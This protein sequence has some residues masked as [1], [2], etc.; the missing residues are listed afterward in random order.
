MKIY[1]Y[2]AITFLLS[3]NMASAQRVTKAPASELNI[4]PG[5]AASVNVFLGTSGD[6]GQLSP[7]AS[8]P[9]SMLS[10]GPQTYPNTH[11]GYEYEAKRFLGFT[12]N[13][14]EGVGC[15]GSGGNILIKPFTGEEADK[16]LIK[17]KQSGTPGY[18]RVSFTNQIIA[19]L[20]AGQK[21]GMHRYRFPAGNNGYLVELAH[22]LANKFVAEGHVAT[23]KALSGWVEART[24][25][26]VGTYK[27]YY[28][29]EFSKRVQWQEIP[30]HK[31][32]AKFITTTEPV[33]IKVGMSSVNTDY[34]KASIFKGTF[35]ELKKDSHDAWDRSLGRIAVTGDPEQRKLFYSLLYRTQQS[36]YL[37]SEPDGTYRG[38]DGKVQKSSEEFYNG[39]SIWDNYRTQLPLL[40][41][42][43]P[44]RYGGMMTSLAALYRSGKKDYATQTE[45]SNTVRTE[46]TIVVLLDAYRKGYPVKFEPIIDSLASEVDHLDYSKPDK[47]LEASYDSW[48]LS[49][50][51][52][53]IHK[54]ELSDK[55]RQK[56]LDY[57]KYW[58]KDF[59]NINANDVDK[60]EARNLYQGTIWQYRWF[61][62]FDVKGLINLTGGVSTFTAQLDQFFNEDH[63]N[64]A[65][66]PDQQVPAMYNAAGQ[67]WK[68][69]ELMHRFAADT[70]IQYFFNDNSKGID[71]FVDKIYKN[72]PKAYIR[73]MD[74]DAGAMSAWYVLTA[75]GLSS[76]CPGWPVYYLNV[77]L[78]K[79]VKINWTGKKAFEIEVLNYGANN[80][81]IKEVTL[82]G[83]TIKRNYITQQ[84]IIAG[85][86]LVI[87][88]SAKPEINALPENWVSSIEP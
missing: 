39:W 86:K 12:H 5:P 20:T 11:T 51:Y 40:S 38:T 47:T 8:Y 15:R 78:M 6:H 13:R 85:G 42:G 65:N 24:T 45:P 57:K 77:P 1:Q 71:P 27:I 16:D 58:E 4:S 22:A 73:T 18:Y 62:P 49:E 67:P 59:K 19:E 79:T 41:I 72:E 74:D 32:I 25:C 10:I 28:C 50:I 87:T 14:F 54:D 21:N 82:N 26:S 7:A 31:L 17:V 63:Y 52:K 48:A 35:E 3:L 76:A 30:G 84:E 61:V 68:S 44:E 83:K 23:D 80:K 81:Y 43:W 64:H 60:V 56:A 33:E 29:L 69:Q 88:A 66:E 36:P 2:L 53:I 9:F 46:R 70:V 34:A 37:I 55:Y 75:C